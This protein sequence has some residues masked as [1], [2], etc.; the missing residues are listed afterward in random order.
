MRSNGG[1]FGRIVSGAIFGGLVGSFGLVG[2][3]G[4]GNVGG[5]P[6]DQTATRIANTICPKAWMCCSADQL[7]S[8]AAAGMN[9]QD[10]ITQTTTNYKSYLSSLQA[11]VDQKR[12]SYQSSKLDTCLMTIQS[13]EC[14]ALNVT[15]HVMGIP[16]CE[17]FT[18]PLV[19]VGG[20]CSQD[21]E[22]V[23]G[24]CN[25]P[26]GSNN[27]EGVCAA[28][29]AAGQSCAAGGG[30]SCGP[31]AVCDTEGTPDVSSDDL[32]AAVSDIGGT[33]TDDL[34]CQSLNCSSSGGSAMVCAAATTPPAAMCFYASGCSAAGGRPGAGTLLLFAA[35]AV[36]AFLRAG[37]ARRD[38]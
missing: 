12:A 16:G 35:F 17:S 4:C 5:I 8:N 32:C 25:V 10:C 13:S 30:P 2:L 31:N 11:S 15:N 38:R 7:M 20:A 34:Q 3:P 26:T 19:A 6:V 29:I 37:R 14:S 9:E 28:F 18:T 36:I 27:G 33:C 24:W 1:R 21:Y 22:C 23:N